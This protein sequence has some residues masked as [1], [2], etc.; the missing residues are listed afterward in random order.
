MNF[1]DAERK[2]ITSQKEFNDNRY[3]NALT[4]KVENWDGTGILLDDV[5]PLGEVTVTSNFIDEMTVTS[6]GKNLLSIN[7]VNVSDGR[8]HLLKGQPTGNFVFSYKSTLSGNPYNYAV[9]EIVLTDGRKLY[10][11]PGVQKRGISGTIK[12]ITFE[13]WC[14][15]TDGGI[16]DIQLEVTDTFFD[17]AN[18]TDGKNSYNNAHPTLFEPYKQGET[19]FIEGHGTGKL[20]PISP[21][22]TLYSDVPDGEYNID[23]NKDINVVINKLTNAIIATGGNV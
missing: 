8:T 10:T 13:N 11:S 4:G 2:I 22:M 23:Y 20:K 9:C 1:I 15:A 17:H 3:A 16:Y 5:S 7:S 18:D 19:V 14:Q 12:Q 6:C 21:N